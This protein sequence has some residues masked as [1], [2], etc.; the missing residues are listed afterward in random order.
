[1]TDLTFDASSVAGLLFAIMRVT[2]VILGAPQ[3]TRR[4]PRTGQTAFA[5]SVGIFLMQPVPES[6]L[7]LGPLVT[8]IV[9]NFAIGIILGFL[10]TLILQMFVVAGGILD[11]TSGLGISGLYDP[12]TGR[13]STV[14]ERFFDLTAL[15]MFFVLGG[16]R[17][18][19]AGIAQTVEV[20]PLWGRPVIDDGLADLAMTVFARFFIAGLEISIPALAALFLAELVLGVAARMLPEANVFLL[21]LPVK[22]LIA[23]L[24]A[25][26]VLL[27]FPTFVDSSL[28]EM[29]D[30]IRAVVASFG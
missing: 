5:L 28:A 15:A 10:A 12:L 18:L 22:L 16:P 4:L 8:S 21:G 20:V 3:L 11:L 14:F 24:A 23:M 25:A 7:L 27:S 13:N 1:M 29:A 2:G 6:E 17:L 26:A 19:V 30:V 9:V